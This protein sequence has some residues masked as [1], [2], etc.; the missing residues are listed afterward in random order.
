LSYFIIIFAQATSFA[1]VGFLPIFSACFSARYLKNRCS[2]I[3]D[4][5]TWHRPMISPHL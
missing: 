4:H 2:Y 1:G 3:Y 5:Q